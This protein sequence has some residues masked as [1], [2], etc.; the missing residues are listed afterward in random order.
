MS[1]SDKPS[2][3]TRTFLRVWAFRGFVVLAVVAVAGLARAGLQLASV[4]PTAIDPTLAALATDFAGPATPSAT[5]AASPDSPEP[6]ATRSTLSGTIVFAARSGGRSHLWAVSQGDPAPVRLTEGD[7]DDRDPAVSAD[8]RWLAFTSNRGG[9][10][11]LYL[12]DLVTGETRALTQTTS[13]E[14]HP[15]WS[16]DGVWIAFERYGGD[17]LDIWILRVDGAGDPIQLTDAPSMD[18]SPTW[19]PAGRRIAFVSDRDGL[20]DIFLADLDDPNERYLNLTESPLISEADPSFSPDGTALAFSGRGDGFDYTYVLAPESPG[21]VRE[22]GPGRRPVWSPSGGALAAILLSPQVSHLV[23]Y[24][25]QS[26]D[27]AVGFPAVRGVEGLAWF[28]GALPGEATAWMP[29]DGDPGQGLASPISLQSG[30][31]SLARLPGIEAPTPMLSDLVDES[32]LELRR[33]ALAE[34]GWDILGRLE[35][36]FVGINAPL[37]PGYAYNDWLY[38]GRAVTIESGL[39][40]SGR[41]EVVRED[42]GAETYWR[43]FVRVEPQDGSRGEPIRVRPW[44]FQTRYTGDPTSYDRGGSLRQALPRGYYVD[45]TEL[46]ADYGFERVPAMSNWR[47]YFPGARFNEYARSDGLTWLQA[48]LQIY[49]PEAV[50]TPTPYRTPTP[51]P[52]ITPRPTA[53]P[54]WWRW[55]LTATASAAGTQTATAAPQP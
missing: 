42:F 12:L 40:G 54:W 7:H 27:L 30:R 35:N 24:P 3:P 25:L 31:V 17:D 16:P 52:T 33:R 47:T 41:L 10:W 1:T 23:V 8:G 45:L 11:D 37:P 29:V 19:D 39:L 51:T 34:I 14:G 9:G 26:A 53:T 55:I 50:V 21:G 38:T 32:F 48:M 46:A 49:P 5:S 36:A 18:A 28:S 4:S 15:T 6:R 20:P 43:L 44:D 22:V 13:F 2:A